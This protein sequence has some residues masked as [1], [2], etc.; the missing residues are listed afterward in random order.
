MVVCQVSN[1]CKTPTPRIYLVTG[2]N[3]KK[4][5]IRTEWF[6]F[7]EPCMST[8]H[9]IA[10]AVPSPASC[11]A[12]VQGYDE[13]QGSLFP[14]QSVLVFILLRSAPQT[15]THTKHPSKVTPCTQEP[16]SVPLWHTWFHQCSSVGLFSCPTALGKRLI[17]IHLCKDNHHRSWPQMENFPLVCLIFSEDVFMTCSLQII[18]PMLLCAC[19]DFSAQIILLVDL[20]HSKTHAVFLHSCSLLL[21]WPILVMQGIQ[22]FPT[23]YHTANLPN[24]ARCLVWALSPEMDGHQKPGDWRNVRSHMKMEYSVCSL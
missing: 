23:F 24:D 22:S 13:H 3:S 8:A 18:C 9:A 21:F 1:P 19:D 20:Y 11:F 15:H 14:V 5:Y 7:W 6:A 2:G 17:Y 10:V 16:H 12:T 4:L